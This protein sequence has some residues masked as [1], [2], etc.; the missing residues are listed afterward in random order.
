VIIGPDYFKTMGIPLLAG[1]PFTDGDNEG[2]PHVVIVNEE[3]AKRTWPGQNALGRSIR[4]QSRDSIPRTIVGIAASV[5]S[6]GALAPPQ[7]ETYIPYGQ[8]INAPMRPRQLVVRTTGDAA[9]VISAIRREVAALDP[10]QPV[11]DVRSM[12]EIVGLPVTRQ[13]FLATLLTAF[14]V[15]ALSLAS[16]GTYG[17]VAYSVAQRTREFGVR[18]ALGAQRGDVLRR[19]LGGSIR[20]AAVG[21]VLG[22]LGGLGLTRYL[23]TLLYGVEPT[24]LATFIVVAGGLTVVAAVAALVPAGRAARVDP[25]TALRAD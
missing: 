9:N 14:G 22:V 11:V 23:A 10:T 20:L 3:L 6:W 25:V 19:V 4:S 7:P 24:D 5:H 16:V 13:R 15:L 21:I 1:R 12:T 8:G 17:V 18:L 2:A